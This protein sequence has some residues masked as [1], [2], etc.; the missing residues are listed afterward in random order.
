MKGLPKRNGEIVDLICKEAG[1]RERVVP[2][3]P[4]L[5][6]REAAA[7]AM[8]LLELRELAEKLRA[9]LEE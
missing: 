7:V 4:T 9:T 1:V 8:F 2:G 5:N 6:K 3:S